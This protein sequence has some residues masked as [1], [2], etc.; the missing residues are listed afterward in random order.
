MRLRVT[1]NIFESYVKTV[2]IV[3]SLSLKDQHD[4]LHGVDHVELHN[5]FTEL[6]CFDLGVV[7]KVLNDKGQNIG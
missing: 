1:Q 4:L 3:Q 7:Q 2:V 6:T 5:V